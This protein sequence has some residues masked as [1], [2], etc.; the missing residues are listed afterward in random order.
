MTNQSE[1]E[2]QKPTEQPRRKTNWKGWLGLAVFIVFIIGINMEK[3]SKDGAAR[4][5]AAWRGAVHQVGQDACDA[6]QWS[7]T[8]EKCEELAEEARVR[9]ERRFDVYQK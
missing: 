3:Y 5:D 8:P 6:Y 2:D 1:H 4:S 7:Q 9:T